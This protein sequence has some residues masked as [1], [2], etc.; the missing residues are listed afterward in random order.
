MI[1]QLI[2]ALARALLVGLMVTLPASLLP[3]TRPDSAQIVVLFALFAGLLTLV[4]YAARYPGLV[5]FRYAPPYNRLRFAGLAV[6]LLLLSVLWRGELAPTTF[7]Q[8]VAALG[9]LFGG[10]LDF[11]YSPVRLMLL[12]LPATTGAEEMATLRAAAGLAATVALAMLAVFAG[13]LW[14]SKWPARRAAF[15]VWVNLPTFDPTA[16]GDVVVRLER[17]ARTNVVLGALLPFVAP[18]VLLGAGSLLT[19][20]SE[21]GAQ[22]QIWVIAAW[23]FLPAALVM[24]GV[25]LARIARM[26]R[27]RREA[28]GDEPGLQPV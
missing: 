2:G 6:M 9:G 3:D 17:D 27:N 10:W 12:T 25:A 14:L 18:A 1:G 16:G 23:A 28:A 26:I 22:T 7:T 4:E 24:R 20:L 11:P 8:F 5:E 19:P 15:N 13:L 21:S